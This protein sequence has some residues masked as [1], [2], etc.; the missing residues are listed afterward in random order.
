M[1]NLE[2]IEELYR[3]FREQDYDAFLRICTPDLE[4]IQNDGFPRGATTTADLRPGL[5]CQ[6]TL[7]LDRVTHLS[8]GSCGRIG[9]AVSAH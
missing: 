7:R 4:W 9:R 5:C 8:I 2:V 6:P 1:N 3:A